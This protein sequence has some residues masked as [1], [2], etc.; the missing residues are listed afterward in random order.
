MCTLKAQLT[1]ALIIRWL[2]WVVLHLLSPAA[3]S[4]M[5]ILPANIELPVDAIADFCQRW[6]VAELS[7]FGSALLE[8]RLSQ[9]CPPPLS[10]MG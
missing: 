6:Q 3:L 4:E 5:G 10:V 1:A 9:T 8:F 2:S 7:L